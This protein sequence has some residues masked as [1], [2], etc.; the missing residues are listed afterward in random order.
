MKTNHT[1]TKQV[2]NTLA[3]VIKQML[4]DKKM[5]Y[6]HVSNGGKLKDLKSKGINVAK[7]V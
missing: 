5:I 1:N 4:D 2:E 6:D 3:T 7:A